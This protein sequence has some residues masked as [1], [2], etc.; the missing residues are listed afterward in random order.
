[1]KNFCGLALAIA[2]VFAAHAADALTITSSSVTITSADVGQTFTINYNG[3]SGGSTIAGLTASAV[4]TVTAV[5]NNSITLS[6]L[7][8]NTS[9]SPITASR[10]SAFGFDTNPNLQSATASGFFNTTVLNSSLPSGFGNIDFCVKNGQN[11]N[12]SGGG[13]TG[14]TIGANG[15]TTMVLTFG[16]SI[17]N[18][19][20]FSNFGVRYQ[21]I[22]GAGNV[23][24]AV[25]HGTPGTPPIPEPTSAAVFGLGALIL[26]ASLRKQKLF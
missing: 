10:I 19:V 7:M 15:T 13:G 8:T 22:A 12:C 4:F 16:S 6:A 24:S 5:T 1:M 3:T 14:I 25:G 20:T 2:M 11:N 26:G 21:S 23:T 9:S 17:T 18:G